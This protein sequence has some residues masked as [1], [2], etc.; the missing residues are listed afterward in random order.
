MTTFAGQSLARS[1][2]GRPVT[3][4]L[5]GELGAGKTTFVQG[6]AQGLGI[7]G[8]QSPTFA[9]EYTAET[10]SG[11]RF[12]HID[13]YRMKPEEAERF[14]HQ[15]RDPADITCVEWP[16]RVSNDHWKE[17]IAITLKDAE[18]DARECSIEF[19]DAVLT[20][21]E[22]IAEWQEQWRLPTEIRAHCKAVADFSC[23]LADQLLSR[24]T[25]VRKQALYQAA[26]LHDL[27]RFLD[28]REGAGPSGFVA[29]EEDHLA[30]NRCKEIYANM[31]H[32]EACAQ[33]LREQELPVLSTIVAPHGL[34][35]P[36]GEHAT[37]EQLLLF[38]ADKRVIGSTVVTVDERF[39][40]FE[41]RYG[42]NPLRAGW[43]QE[44]KRVETLLFPITQL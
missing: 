16:D 28:F 39:A 32:E 12:S 36:P 2:Y 17:A 3:I 15:Q 22:Q 10:A 42:D 9:L 6:F 4:S 13:L 20:T 44:T 38:Y 37:T 7:A 25:I 35:N 24:G 33:F 11:E 31:H 43:M 30:W 40:D 27:F 1:L 29:T 18:S 26:V 5:Q 23:A 41:K 8:A 34:T 14:L 19:R 21:E